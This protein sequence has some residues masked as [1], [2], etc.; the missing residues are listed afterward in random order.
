MKKVNLFLAG[1]FFLLLSTEANAQTK[2]GADYFKGK[3]NVVTYAS[4]GDRKMIVS[5]EQKDGKMTGAI[6]DTVGVEMFVV[7]S[8]EMKE[9]QVTLNFTSQG[10]DVA[11]FLE[12]KDEDHLTGNAFGMFDAKGVRIK[13]IKK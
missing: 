8:L 6:L 9:N 13:E 3:W 7:T 5:F 11:L 4:N 1:M 12:K 10:Y 2:T